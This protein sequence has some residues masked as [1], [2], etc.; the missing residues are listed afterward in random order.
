MAPEDLGTCL[1]CL[2]QNPTLQ[3]LDSL[4]ENQTSSLDF[5][6]LK[7]VYLRPR[8]AEP[9]F[10]ELVEVFRVGDPHQTGLIAKGELERLCTNVGDALDPEEFAMMM[11]K[12]YVTDGGVDYEDL[13]AKMMR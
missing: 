6:A 10:E 4:L 11:K 9:S 8:D 3:E 2:G 1:R 5:A 12:A 7:Q 13:V